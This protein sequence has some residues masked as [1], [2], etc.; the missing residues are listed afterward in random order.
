MTTQYLPALLRKI[1]DSDAKRQPFSSAFVSLGVQVDFERTQEG[2]I[3]L[4]NKPGRLGDLCAAA[5]ELLKPNAKL[6]FKE[7]LS[8]RGKVAFAEGQTHAKVTAPLARLLSRWAA[9]RFPRP[10]SEEMRVALGQA[11]RHFQVAG[12]RVIAPISEDK[13][14]LVFVDGAC[15]D[16]VSIG[17]VLLV[18]GRAP[19]YFGAI[20]S[21]GTVDSWKSRSDQEQVIGQAELFPLLVARLTW[22]EHLSDRRVLYFIDNES[23]RI[24]AI[25]AYS[26][27]L[28]SLHIITECLGW[29]FNAN[30]QA[31]YA[32][33]PTCANIAD[34]PSRMKVCE[35]LKSLGAFCVPPIFPVGTMPAMVLE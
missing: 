15:E 9:I 26:P 6:G 35:G 32:R 17:G 19:E 23:A 21:Q 22:H 11:V 14:C 28:A 24:A 25:K 3:L 10:V 13:P 18:P 2:V 4:E 34:S 1:A 12:P 30:S 31:W 7:A 33:V 16:T 27:V 29:D 20:V 8:L 5:D